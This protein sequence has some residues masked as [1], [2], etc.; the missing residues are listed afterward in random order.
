[1]ACVSLVGFSFFSYDT[2]CTLK[3]YLT[4]NLDECKEAVE[5]SISKVI[6]GKNVKVNYQKKEIL[7]KDTPAVKIVKLI[8]FVS[9]SEYRTNRIDET[10]NPAKKLKKIFLFIAN[11][12]L[13][14]WKTI[15]VVNIDNT[16]ISFIF[17]VKHFEFGFGISSEPSLVKFIFTNASYHIH[18]CVLFCVFA[19]TV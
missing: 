4:N 18:D 5:Y 19:F 7:G 15:K 16:P 6:F 11:L 13:L 8:I 1:M 9:K 14:N 10:S 17:S 3:F 12:A 2:G